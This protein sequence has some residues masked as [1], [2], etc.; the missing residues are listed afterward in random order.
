MSA[1]KLVFGWFFLQSTIELGSPA[2][3]GQW[4][5]LGAL[6]LESKIFDRFKFI[7][8]LDLAEF[9]WNSLDFE[10]F[11]CANWKRSIWWIADASMRWGISQEPATSLMLLIVKVF[12]ELV[13]SLFMNLA[14]WTTSERIK[15][16]TSELLKFKDAVKKW[17]LKRL[18]FKIWSLNLVG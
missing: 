14:I 8:R 13:G 9:D 17:A 12:L 16:S 1:L 2:S 11:D 7:I 5:G 10:Y 6:I 4:W 3:G 18:N 15:W